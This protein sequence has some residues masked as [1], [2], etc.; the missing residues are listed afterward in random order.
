MQ[1]QSWPHYTS[2][3]AES[4]VFQKGWGTSFPRCSQPF[5]FPWFIFD[6]TL[7]P[8]VYIPLPTTRLADLNRLDAGLSRHLFPPWLT[9]CLRHRSSLGSSGWFLTVCGVR[10]E[11]K[12]RWNG[13]WN[14]GGNFSVLTFSF[15]RGF[16]TFIYIH[17]FI[18]ST[19]KAWVC[20]IPFCYI[21]NVTVSNFKND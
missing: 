10:C 2:S 14:Y 6:G 21:R 1:K 19:H 4:G 7:R 12:I 3:K 20:D 13:K 17:D 5:V 16:L 8:W 11:C 9:N 18:L 15:K